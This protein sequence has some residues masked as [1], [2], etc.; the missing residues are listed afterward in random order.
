LLEQNNLLFAE[1]NPFINC[2]ICGELSELIPILNLI[3]RLS[4]F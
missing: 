3:L 2:K 1:H 4:E